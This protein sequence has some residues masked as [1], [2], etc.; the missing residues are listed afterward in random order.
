MRISTTTWPFERPVRKRG[1][2]TGWALHDNVAKTVSLQNYNYFSVLSDESHC[3]EHSV[4]VPVGPDEFF[5]ATATRMSGSDK[6]SALHQ[7]ADVQRRGGRMDDARKNV[8]RI[9][10]ADRPFN[11]LVTPD[12]IC[13]I[14]FKVSEHDLVIPR[15]MISMVANASVRL[16]TNPGPSWTAAGFSDKREVLPLIPHIVEKIRAGHG[17]RARCR[18]AGR[19]ALRQIHEFEQ[20]DSEG[21]A[22]GRTIYMMDFEEPVVASQFTKP[23]IDRA[24]TYGREMW[25]GF[26]KYG[27]DPKALYDLIRDDDAHA[28][29][30]ISSFDLSAGTSAKNFAFDVMERALNLTDPRD[31]NAFEW[32][33]R[34]VCDPYLVTPEG[35]TVSGGQF[36]PSGSG[37]TSIVGTIISYTV[38][39]DAVRRLRKTGDFRVGAAGDDTFISVKD[40]VDISDKTIK[41]G[42]DMKSLSTRLSKIIRNSTGFQL[43]TDESWF[44]DR[45][46]VGYI[47]PRVPRII[48]DGSS[49]AIKEWR[50]ER[51]AELGRTLT[52]DEKFIKLDVE[53]VEGAGGR[54]HRWGYHFQGAFRFL[55]HFLK[56]GKIGDTED[57]FGREVTAIRPTPEVLVRLQ[58]PENKPPKNLDTHVSRLRAALIENYP[59]RLV[60]NRLMYYFYGAY[61]LNKEGVH[62]R[63]Q[64]RIERKKGK[65]GRPFPFRVPGHPL[66]DL[67]V[68]DPEFAEFWD[69]EL[70]R[71]QGVWSDLFA[72]RD[73]DF[74]RARALRQGI[75]HVHARAFIF[76]NPYECQDAYLYSD[77]GLTKFGAFGANM[78]SNSR[79]REKFISIS[80]Q[81]YDSD[82]IDI[83]GSRCKALRAF[84]QD[85]SLLLSAAD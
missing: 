33:R 79:L 81:Y 48:L 47:Q 37:W 54:T 53:P 13:E 38:V 8:I 63:A 11:V 65:Y 58:Y 26:N 78:M 36:L 5:I 46:C 23:L 18:A 61:R 20:R 41:G 68:E 9:D 51:A 28:N 83:Y 30:D 77:S 7:N 60:R 2:I 12:E 16:G 34:Q 62:T 21:K 17:R 67:L 70:I 31:K 42:G 57:V 22:L 44:S 3:S 32:A 59:N 82:R 76:S 55:S 40:F 75:T 52:F 71:A 43:K 6:R 14:F 45:A 50:K 69:S 56:V 15:D 25:L 39:Y 74:S 4:S 64:L 10:R 24:R 66:I 19:T 35:R 72:H 84:L 85:N 73:F 27:E 80:M 29:L 1:V 49:L